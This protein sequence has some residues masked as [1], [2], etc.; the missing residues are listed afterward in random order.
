MKPNDMRTTPAVYFTSRWGLPEYTDW[1]DESMSWKQTCSIGDWSFL[2]ERRFKGP[3]AMRLLSDT[4]INSLAKFETLQAK[5]VVHC[6]DQG[7]II[8]E[9]I[10]TR[11]SEDEFVL[12]GRGTF[13]LDYVRRKRGYQVSSIGVESFNFQV[14]G[15]NALAMV[16]KAAGIALRDVK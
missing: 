15:P 16:E 13:W 3:D 8:A 5:H 7:K 4:S 12:F 10:A 1:I 11:L 6:N 14:A 2:W 9:G